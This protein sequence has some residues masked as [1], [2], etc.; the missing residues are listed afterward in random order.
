MYRWFLYCFF[1]T[2]DLKQAVAAAYT[3]FLA[4]PNHTVMLNNLQYYRKM[5][6][7]HPEDFVNLEEKDYQVCSLF[8]VLLLLVA[9]INRFVNWIHY[10]PLCSMTLARTT[11]TK[12]FFCFCLLDHVSQLI[13]VPCWRGN[14][15]RP[16]NCWHGH[17]YSIRNTLS[18]C[19]HG[20]LHN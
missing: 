7:V 1:Q 17:V 6:N 3:Y 2:N 18:L 5:P 19:N 12:L 11:I 4:N 10:M 9:L 13:Y 16:V 8:V 20:L 15:V 14:L